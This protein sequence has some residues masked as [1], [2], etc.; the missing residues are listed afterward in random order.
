[1]TVFGNLCQ[2]GLW[3]KRR[4]EVPFVDQ[5]ESGSQGYWIFSEDG[6]GY[7]DQL[8]VYQDYKAY[9]CRTLLHTYS[10]MHLLLFG[11]HSACR[12]R[13]VHMDWKSTVG[14]IQVH[15]LQTDWFVDTVHNI[16]LLCCCHH[17]Y[18]WWVHFSKVTKH[19]YLY[20]L[21][22]TVIVVANSSTKAVMKV[23]DVYFTSCLVGKTKA[24]LLNTT[25]FR[26]SQDMIWY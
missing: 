3:K 8:S 13:R 19:L 18:R 6:K 7:T 12:A 17:G 16:P 10:S 26:S 23:N 21:S 11:Y 15:T 20:F 25:H 14:W 4:V 5:V 9:C 1:M 24:N 22:S 2:S